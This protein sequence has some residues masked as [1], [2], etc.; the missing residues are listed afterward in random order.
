MRQLNLEST[1]EEHSKGIKAGAPAKQ[2]QGH[3]SFT[4]KFIHTCIHDWLTDIRCLYPFGHRNKAHGLLKH[5]SA[6]TCCVSSVVLSSTFSFLRPHSVSINFRKI[7]I[8]CFGDSVLQ[9]N[10]NK[11]RIALI[12]TKQ[13]YMRALNNDSL[14]GWTAVSAGCFAEHWRHSLFFKARN[15]SKKL[16]IKNDWQNI[17][18]CTCCVSSVVLSS[19]FSFLRPHSVS[20]NL[21]KI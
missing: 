16:A 20:I 13:S 4:V 10:T 9:M 17:S 3:L 19:T 14:L 5:V 11:L 12:Y 18:F 15:P 2:Q 7:K 8:L 21:H 1:F 6:C